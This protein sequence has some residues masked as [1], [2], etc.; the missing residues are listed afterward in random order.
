MAGLLLLLN[1]MVVRP[2][3]D[4]TAQVAD[5]GEHQRFSP[6]PLGK[7][8]DEIGQLYREFRN[9]TTQLEKVHQGYREANV[10]LEH[11]VRERSL[12][13]KELRLNQERLRALSS[14]L[15]MAE[16]RERRRIAV[17]LH[18]R[19]GQALAVLRLQVEL[20]LG[21]APADPENAGKIRVLIEDIIHDS[22]TLIFEISPPVLYEL[23]LGPAI[24]WLAEEI[25][26]YH[27]I[28]IEVQDRLDAPLEDNVRA[29]IFRSVRELLYNVVKHAEADRARVRLGQA[30]NDIRI[31]VEDNGIGFTPE[32]NHKDERNNRGFGLFSIQERFHQLGGRL[33]IA[34]G[35]RGGT[36]ITLCTP[37]A[38]SKGIQ[39]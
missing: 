38:L 26:A 31:V 14:E 39:F 10:R 1:R 37:L 28:R 8:R 17:E 3:L 27:D 19:I 9:M 16:E 6:G 23:G 33:D 2:L 15:V 25:M 29:M 21:Q 24:E 35:D 5:F 18:D 12:T 20:L 4:L 30:G 32:K 36:M 7:R 11:E 13:E 22:R 34:A